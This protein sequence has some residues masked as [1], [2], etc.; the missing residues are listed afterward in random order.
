MEDKKLLLRGVY[1]LCYFPII[2]GIV[3]FLFLY[4]FPLFGLFLLPRIAVFVVIIYSLL[5]YGIILI[6]KVSYSDL[7]VL[8]EVVIPNAP[9]DVRKLLLQRTR[10]TNRLINV[11][12][13]S[14]IGKKT[15][16]QSDIVKRVQKR[17]VS[18]SH[19]QINKYLSA[20]EEA[21]MMR[22]QKG[23]YTRE[24]CLTEKGKWCLEAI[25]KCLPKRQVWFIIRHYFQC[26]KLR[27]FPETTE[28][29]L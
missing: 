22:S 21:G 6:Q 27:P 2:V 16:I 25:K 14:S 20:L 12:I 9:K 4:L 23:G 8:E 7:N 19:T 5:F 1:Q 28:E 3:A 24:Y 11:I 13:L 10:G 15:V 26:R 18:L 17:D 29:K